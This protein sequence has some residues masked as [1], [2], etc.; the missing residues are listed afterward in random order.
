MKFSSHLFKFTFDSLFLYDFYI[1]DNLPALS[2]NRPPHTSYF[3]FWRRKKI[4]RKNARLLPTPPRSS[5]FSRGLFLKS[6]RQLSQQTPNFRRKNV[7]L[8]NF[9]DISVFNKNKQQT[10]HKGNGET[11]VNGTICFLILLI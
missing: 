7:L 9:F 1:P 6:P 5:L 8:S 11:Y 4:S 10:Q 3:I 2:R